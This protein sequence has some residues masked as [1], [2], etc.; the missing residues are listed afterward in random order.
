MN[1]LNVH[2]RVMLASLGISVWRARRFDTRATEEVEK[3]HAT[4]DIGRFN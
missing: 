2:E 1:I 3:N 4:K